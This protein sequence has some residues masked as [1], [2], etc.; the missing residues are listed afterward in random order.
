MQSLSSAAATTKIAAKSRIRMVEDNGEGGEGRWGEECVCVCAS[1][2]RRM[3]ASRARTCTR[4]TRR[5]K[6]KASDVE[7]VVFWGRNF[8]QTNKK[9]SGCLVCFQTA[10]IE[11]KILYNSVKLIYFLRFNGVERK[12]NTKTVSGVIPDEEGT[13]KNHALNRLLKFKAMRPCCHDAD[14]D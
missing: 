10:K 7:N 1:E 2:E 3:R 9:P 11:K 14:I 4:R 5:R 13:S 6:R 8:F 12:K